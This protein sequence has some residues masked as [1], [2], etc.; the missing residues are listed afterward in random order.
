[1]NAI[2]YLK[3]DVTVNSALPT[4]TRGVRK[5]AVAEPV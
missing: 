3:M 1:M 4:H 2:A 5:H